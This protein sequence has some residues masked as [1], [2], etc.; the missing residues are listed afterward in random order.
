MQAFYFDRVDSTNDQAGRLLREGRIGDSAYVVARGQSAGKGNR[1]RKWASPDDAGIYLT[2]V[3]RPAHSDGD[4]RRLNPAAP[5]LLHLFTRAAGVA[6]AETLRERTNVDVRLKPIN[7]LYVDGRKLG[8]I[9]TEAVIEQGCIRA[10][11]TGVG[12]NVRR[13]ERA[14]PAD[15]VRPISLEELMPPEV[16]AALDV[17]G[18]TVALAKR[19]RR[20]NA[21]VSGTEGRELE[22]AWQKHVL[23]S[24][25]F[26]SDRGCR[27]E[28]G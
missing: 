14:L 16:F 4:P 22:E 10:L 27:V 3:D 19:I 25:G 5:V 17:P 7:D 12:I 2:V 24:D 11:I 23:R 9:L 13:A 6:C 18:L 28:A 20:W 26:V 15:H 8:G 21:V 1:G